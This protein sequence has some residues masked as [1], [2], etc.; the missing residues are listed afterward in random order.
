[1][2]KIPGDV[3]LDQLNVAARRVLLDGL[4]ALS[5]HLDAVV[6]I[7]A[8]AVYLRTSEAAVAGAAFTSDG[9]LGIDPE[10]LRDRPLIEEA[11]KGAGF[12]LRD[13]HQPG[14]WAR[15]VPVGARTVDV[16][17]DVLVGSSF[18][19]GRR[20]ARIPPHDTMCAKKVPG[21]EV[22]VV[23][24]SPMTIAS[25]DPEDTRT[26]LVDVAGA[27]ALLVAKAYKIADRLDDADRRPHRLTD[28]D[29]GDVVRL[30]MVTP[31]NQAA[32]TFKA[33]QA[34]DRVGEVATAG[35][36]LLR[37]QFGGADTAGV[38]MAVSALAGSVPEARIRALAPA[39]VSRIP[40]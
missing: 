30:M 4:G 14:L 18:V 29:A 1:M 10:R 28:K 31:A 39:F 11:L 27:A 32:A 6:V 12:H 5:E 7:G 36:Q 35:L 23:D 17:L 21:I 16:E 25:L 22:A 20:S 40:A 19:K 33:L 2:S 37:T 8:Q 34:H 38:R 3:E 9:D 15:T 13:E 24:R 26:V